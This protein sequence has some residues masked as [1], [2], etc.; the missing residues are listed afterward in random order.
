L[1]W[2]KV[3]GQVL[4]ARVESSLRFVP[5]QPVAVRFRV[6]MASLFDAA[7]GERL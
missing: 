1:V 3:G 2:L 6:A 5:G 7:N 4:S